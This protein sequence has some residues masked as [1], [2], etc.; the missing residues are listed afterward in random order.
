VRFAVE[1]DVGALLVPDGGDPRRADRLWQHTCFETF[2]VE[3]EGEGGYFELNFAPSTEWAVYHFTAYRT[4]MTVVE[5]ARPPRIS[6]SR[7]A[8]RLS[9][10]A[11]IDLESLP[12][13]QDSPILRLALSA[14]VE[15]TQHRLSY[16]ALAHPPGKPDF[17]HA[18]GFALTVTQS[19]FRRGRSGF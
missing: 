8:G 6:V 12:A 18:D 14:V 15:D 16:W 2:V 5:A 9:L 19:H 13:L 7:E 10:D 3:Q 1:G 11:V 4:G 17:H